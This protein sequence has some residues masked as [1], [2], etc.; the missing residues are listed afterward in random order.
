TD[1][2]LTTK[3]RLDHHHAYPGTM[4]EGPPILRRNVMRGVEDALADTRV[5]LLHGARQ[6]GKST[7]SEH[8]VAGRSNARS[9][10]L[11]DP[12]GLAAARADPVGFVQQQAGLFF[13]DEVQRAPD[14]LLAIK[15]EVDRDQRPGQSLLTGSAQVL[16]LPTVADALAGRVEP[17][18]LWP[19]S[20][21]EL[22]GRCEDFV[23]ALITGRGAIEVQ[24]S[25]QKADY[26]DFASV[27][28]YPEV[29]RR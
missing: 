19:F 2:Y 4:S 17:I 10:T 11:D 6:V 3:L 5:V 24:T 20:Q 12:V 18:E 14:L 23:A 22:R 29:N 27:G 8:V 16:A 15:A 25:L 9:V 21:G 26:L 13:I 1:G 28:G 7:L